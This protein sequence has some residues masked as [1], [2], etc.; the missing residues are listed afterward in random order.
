MTWVEAVTKG[1]NFDVAPLVVALDPDRLL[2]EEAV[3]AAIRDRGYNVLE[4]DDE[5][6]FRLTFETTVRDH[7]D[8]PLLVIHF[9]ER[10]EDVPFDLLMAATVVEPSLTSLFQ[11][12][13][14][15]VIRAIERGDLP[16]LFEAQQ[17]EKPSR[18]MTRRPRSSSFSMCT[19][20]CPRYCGRPPTFSGN[21]YACIMVP[22]SCQ[23]LS[24]PGWWSA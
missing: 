5:M 4:L 20:W 16:A 21:F 23:R 6:A 11:N 13:S 8:Q 22:A 10:R 1:L 17:R 19:A 9:G 24:P 12:L 2:T 7:T 3:Q 14:A 18:R 15:P